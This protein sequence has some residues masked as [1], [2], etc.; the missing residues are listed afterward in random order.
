MNGRLDVLLEDKN[1]A[2]NGGRGAISGAVARAI[3]RSRAKVFLAS[4]TVAPLD[5]VTEEISAAGGGVETARV[6]A[7]DE[8]DF[9]KDADAL[10]EKAGSINISFN[11][12]EMGDVQGTPLAEMSLQ[13]FTFLVMSWT[14][15]QFLIWTSSLPLDTIGVGGH[16]EEI[17]GQR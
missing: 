15:T 13:D 6:V 7:L 17:E 8:Q 5:A 1:A 3:A 9:E 16:S 2:I 10:A 4:R 14:R 11:T 12:I